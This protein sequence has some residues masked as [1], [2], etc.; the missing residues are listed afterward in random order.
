MPSA[1]ISNYEYNAQK[2]E[3]TI[4]FRSGSS[5]RYPRASFII[6]GLSDRAQRLMPCT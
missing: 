2:R 3:L 5:K 1:V 4:I 6:E